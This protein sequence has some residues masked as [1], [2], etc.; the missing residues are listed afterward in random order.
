[1]KEKR[2]GLD[3]VLSSTS[4]LPAVETDDR[5]PR[6]RPKVVSGKR[7]GIRQQT[8]Y[9]PEA[10][11]QQLR[12]LAYEEETKMHDY[13]MHGLDLVFKEKG[14]KPIDELTGRED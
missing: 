2:T 3:Q 14:L 6:E 1:M 13:L 7:P 9:L 8:A 10:V 11:Y 12:K 5:P 4:R